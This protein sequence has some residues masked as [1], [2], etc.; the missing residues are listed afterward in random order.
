MIEYEAV[1]FPYAM[2]DYSQ[3]VIYERSLDDLLAY[4]K[5]Y[6]YSRVRKINEKIHNMVSCSR[7]WPIMKNNSND[8]EIEFFSSAEDALP[9]LYNNKT[10]TY[11]RIDRLPLNSHLTVLFWCNSRICFKYMW[12][13]RGSMNNERTSFATRF[14]LKGPAILSKIDLSLWRAGIQ[15]QEALRLVPNMGPDCWLKTN[16]FYHVK[17]PCEP[18]SL[19]QL[20]HTVIVSHNLKKF[21]GKGKLDLTNVPT[22]KAIP[23]S[24]T[25]PRFY[26]VV[27]LTNPVRLT[28]PEEYRRNFNRNDPFLD[29]KRYLAGYV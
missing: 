3:V 8:L 11:E 20:C 18:L 24:I 19:K 6:C 5:R 29:L 15:K 14:R 27:M 9:L 1:N 2:K 10:K 25:L 17:T 7:V 13:N 26:E 4:D 12:R 16:I 22:G 21:K 28:D 23:R